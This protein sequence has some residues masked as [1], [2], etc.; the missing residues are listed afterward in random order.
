[1]T[2]PSDRTELITDVVTERD[3]PQDDAEMMKYLEKM[4]TGQRQNAVQLRQMVGM[5]F[6]ASDKSLEDLRGLIKAYIAKIEKVN[7]VA[8]AREK[9]EELER[10][11]AEAEKLAEQQQRNR[12]DEQ[13]TQLQCGKR[14]KGFV[15]GLFSGWGND[16]IDRRV[17]I[18]Y[19]ARRQRE[20]AAGARRQQARIPQPEQSVS[21]GVDGF[22]RA[23]DISITD[24]QTNI[25]PVLQLRD[26]VARIVR[27]MQGHVEVIEAYGQNN[28]DTGLVDT[29]EREMA[30]MQQGLLGMMGELNNIEDQ[31]ASRKITL[32]ILEGQLPFV[33][34]HLVSAATST[35]GAAEILQAQATA[36]TVRDF[37]QKL[38]VLATKKTGEAV[39]G[40]IDTAFSTPMQIET[41]EK[42]HQIRGTTRARAAAMV[43]DGRAKRAL[44][45]QQGRA[46][47]EQEAAKGRLPALNHTLSLPDQRD[48]S[49]KK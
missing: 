24:I 44:I 27:D 1:M 40:T 16:D 45:L 22:L 32:E 9:A 35:Q 43:S 37:L 15:A 29:L 33:V 41:I 28:P 18:I 7:G 19:E 49:S 6:K 13:I 36:G 8:E 10:L 5:R 47:L 3:I 4:R 42:V 48:D 2:Q 12:E 17:D 23:F 30:T 39:L 31:L 26:Q 20:A 46:L 11:E 38:T 21:E 25:K 34:T 14:K